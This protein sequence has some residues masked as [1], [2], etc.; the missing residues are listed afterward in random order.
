MSE[1]LRRIHRN[2]LRTHTAQVLYARLC[3]ERRK[4]YG[5][6]DS[7]AEIII[8][9]AATLEDIM[10]DLRAD[11]EKKGTV[12][13]VRNGRQKFMKPNKSVF[14]LTR[15]AERQARLC[16]KLGT[17]GGTAPAGETDPDGLDDF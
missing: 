8:Y 10:N 17:G 7:A 4:N 15:V 16:A 9:N 14:E 2:G 6:L 5:T 13:T 1:E 3:R 11:I 12:E